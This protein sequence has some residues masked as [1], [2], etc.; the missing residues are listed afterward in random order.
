M[1]LCVQSVWNKNSNRKQREGS[2]RKRARSRKMISCR[3]LLNHTVTHD[4]SDNDQA[5]SSPNVRN[6]KKYWKSKQQQNR[7]HIY[8]N[9]YICGVPTQ[10]FS[11]KITGTK[12]LLSTKN[13]N[14]NE[15]FAENFYCSDR[16]DFQFSSLWSIV[17]ILMGNQ[18]ER[19]ISERNE[20]SK[21]QWWKIEVL[22][23]VSVCLCALFADSKHLFWT[24]DDMC[25]GLSYQQ[26]KEKR[27]CQRQL[28]P[29]CL[30]GIS[31]AIQRS[32]SKFDRAS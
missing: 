10:E 9:Y 3:L 31:W 16:P 4:K 22:V 26:G 17:I 1:N 19:E 25:G 24:N 20:N 14:N 12:S 15:F 21:M 8:Q 18:T 27:R 7:F 28:R 29:R 32:K 23:R 11:C 30:H 6:R 5:T 13:R 2:E